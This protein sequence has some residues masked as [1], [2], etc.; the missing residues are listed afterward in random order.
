MYIPNTPQPSVENMRT[1]KTLSGIPQKDASLLKTLLKKFSKKTSAKDVKPN[2]NSLLSIVIIESIHPG[3]AYYGKEYLGATG[4]WKRENNVISSTPGWMA[5]I[6]IPIDFVIDPKR[7]PIFFIAI[8][9]KRI[10]HLTSK[11]IL[12]WE[13]ILNEN[14]P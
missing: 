12:F 11:E 2:S 6:F 10:K 8:K 13:K 1:A 5:G 14:A 3:D 4:V 9:V 7:L